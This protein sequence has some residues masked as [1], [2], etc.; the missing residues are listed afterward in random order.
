MLPPLPR[1]EV[2]KAIE[3]RRPA[4]VPMALHIYAPS[5]QCPGR[6]AEAEELR[7]AYP[8]DVLF[9]VQP[10]P[11]VWAEPWTPAG[12]SW[13]PRPPPPGI[14]ET[15][16]DSRVA[17]AD[18]SELDAI[19]ACRPDPATARPAPCPEDPFPRGDRYTAIH[20]WNGLFE[21]AW[22][23]R[24]MENLLAD[25]QTDPVPVHRLFEAITDFNC[26]ITGRAAREHAVD[27]VWITDDLGAQTG[28]LFS[29][30]MFRRFC[31]PC[32]ARMIRTAHENGMH[33]WLHSCGRIDIFLEDLIAI[34]LDVIHPVQKHAM[35]Q[36]ETAARFGGR[37]AFWAGVDMQR[38][39]PFG[40][41]DDVR[42]EVRFLVDT[43]DRPDGGCLL[44]LGNVITPDVP[45]AN[46][47]AL[48][49]EACNYGLAHRQ[50]RSRAEAAEHP[51]TGRAGT[52]QGERDQ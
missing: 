11:T 1:D 41:P 14:G 12:Y 27:G 35:D 7:R 34:G 43:F 19:L 8:S 51:G 30:E 48:F 52:R 46:W 36:R 9:L 33:F 29:L 6:E 10:M 42:R 16:H 37:I 23:L 38:V 31:K 26:A 45:F 28:P 50:G 3:H 4:R 20:W 25:M 32:Y 22:H 39:L 47:Q 2:C 5:Q 15:A 44:A 40:T 13:L 21:R 18:W 17:L 49:D 24:G